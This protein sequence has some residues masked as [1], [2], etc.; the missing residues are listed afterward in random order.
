M[1]K[2]HRKPMQWFEGRGIWNVGGD[3]KNID[4]CISSPKFI[5]ILMDYFVYFKVMAYFNVD[6]TV[7]NPID[8]R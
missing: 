8:D 7:N 4:F 3:L 5:K 1:T 6:F 2:N